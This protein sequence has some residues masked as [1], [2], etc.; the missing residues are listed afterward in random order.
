MPLV[1]VVVLSALQGLA[2]ALP[3]SRSGHGAVARLWL[4]PERSG[5]ALEAILQ[6]G[7]ALALGVAC[8]RRLL[9]ALGEGVRAIARPALLRISPGARD[10]ALLAFGTAVSLIVAQILGPRVEGLR[11]APVAVGTALIVTGLAL[12][13]TLLAPRTGDR[14]GRI[15]ARRA[16]GEPPSGW[17]MLIV[18]AVHGLAIFPGASRVG[19]ALVVL[20]FLGVRPARAVDLALLLTIPALLLA[21]AQALLGGGVSIGLDTSAVVMG[22]LLAFLAAMLASS[23]L[24][25]LVDQRRLGALALWVIPLGLAMLAYARAL[26]PPGA[27]HEQTPSGSHA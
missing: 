24:R 2:E 22:L 18:G 4:E 12:A 10:A 15:A 16:G 7:T 3:I 19:A 1:H 11:D 13:S 25:A 21:F 17:G 27:T 8:R 5:A 6:L 26:P 20:L 14:F 9:N 23:V